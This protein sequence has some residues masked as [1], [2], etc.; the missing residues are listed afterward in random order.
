MN[1][2][3]R[4]L[5]TAAVS[6][7]GLLSTPL[8]AG[9]A[10]GSL[11]LT[12]D[13]AVEQL[14]HPAV[15]V[16]ALPQR[17]S[18]AL[19]A[20]VSDFAAS[21]GFRLDPTA[22]IAAAQLPDAVSGRLAVLVAQLGECHQ[23]AAP[24]R[25]MLGDPAVI[26]ALAVAPA[27]FAAA[28]SAALAETAARL[29]TCAAR[30]MSL[31]MET[32]ALLAAGR[33]VAGEALDLW[34]VLSYSPSLESQS[35]LNDYALIVDAGGD[36]YYRNN[37]GGSFLDLKRGPEGSPAPEQAPARGCHQL[38]AD[39]PNGDCTPGVALLLDGS[40]NDIYGTLEDPDPRDDAFCTSDQVARRIVTGG[41]ALAGVGIL[42][43]SA[44]DDR[45]VG[46]TLAQG[47][48]HL[49][50]V[51]VLRDESGDDSYLAIRNA[52]GF[53]LLAGLGIL[54]DESGDDVFDRYLPSALDPAAPFQRR[55][56]GGVLDD[57]GSCDN[58]ARQMQGSGFLPGG[59]GILDN[60]SGNDIYRGPT[61]AIQKFD[62]N[63]EFPHG[64]QG[65]GGRGGAGALFDGG[66]RDA[67]EGVPGRAD[68]VS[69]Q[70]G[71]DSAGVFSDSGS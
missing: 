1:H 17:P 49:A 26:E 12:S 11:P 51:G 8:A 61:P 64:S 25:A 68:N 23:V 27:G 71:P 31:A 36:D 55:G 57:R 15:V 53:G 44:G 32:S 50:G 45:Y 41:S 29:K 34:P 7:A 58:L 20:A 40:G 65:Y 18:E 6:T 59:V 13:P 3:W 67:Y 46:K 56:A 37:S 9:G 69:I 70:P 47:S 63:I 48:G 30:L 42:V 24:A 16:P 35:Y 5:G 39:G 52:Q 38:N 54:S 10:P 22:R 60:H 14:L 33:P 43:D 62:P 2:R 66:G 21:L 19:A 4:L 28:P